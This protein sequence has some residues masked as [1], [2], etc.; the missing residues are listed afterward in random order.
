MKFILDIDGVMVHANPHRRIELEDDGFYRF[1][2]I[3]VDILKSAIHPEEGDE[4]VLSTSHRYRFSIHEWKDIF[5]KR[6]IIFNKISILDSPIRHQNTRKTEI[7]TWIHKYNCK[8]EEIIIIDDDKSLNELP[9]LF[10]NRLVLTNSYTGL[11]NY[12][13]LYRVLN[14]SSKSTKRSNITNQEEV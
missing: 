6:G 11:N 10:K 1:N 2:A 8:S 7:L 3:A 9:Q 5:C 4:L 12:S 13:E 14:R